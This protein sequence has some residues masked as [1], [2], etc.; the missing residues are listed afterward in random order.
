MKTSTAAL[1]EALIKQQRTLKL[2]DHAFARKLGI[3]K[4]LWVMTRRGDTPVG[5]SLLAGV[6]REF[7]GLNNEVL[8][9][10]AEHASGHQKK[11]RAPTNS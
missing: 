8:G 2:S 10:L 3:S 9:A 6:V 1:L 7:S 11:K 4:A 5:I